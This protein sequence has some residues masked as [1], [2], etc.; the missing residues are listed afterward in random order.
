M[1]FLFTKLRVIY[2]L[3]I[4]VLCLA[5]ISIPDFI[6]LSPT[7]SI[8]LFITYL[9][10][11][12]LVTFIFNFLASKKHNKIIQILQ[13]ECD[14]VKYLNVYYPLTQKRVGKKLKSL[15]LLNLASG[16]ISV[17]DYAQA[18]NVLASIDLKN[19][20]PMNNIMFHLHLTSLNI[21]EGNIAQAGKA[22]DYV[23]NLISTTKIP[24][25]QIDL[26][27]KTRNLYTARIRIENG[28][29]EDVEQILL[30]LVASADCMYQKISV[31]YTLANFYIKQNR[32]NE[33]IREMTFVAENGNTLFIAQKARE[34]L[35]T[36][37]N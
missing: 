32:L 12:Y 21:N 3:T 8:L 19:S 6:D 35:Q 30:G 37:N 15:L 27:N 7:S 5:I 14:P 24:Q 17:G 2:S 11:I 33:A 26:L 29:F 18:K 20:K 16:Y 22:L 36:V 9:I 34:F 10:E 25:T 13:D 23:S 28:Y 31:K 4:F 1:C